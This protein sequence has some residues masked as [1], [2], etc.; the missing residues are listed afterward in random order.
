[1]HPAASSKQL[2]VAQV[3]APDYITSMFFQA[4][5]VAKA[6]KKASFLFPSTVAVS[7]IYLVLSCLICSQVAIKM[8]WQ[9]K[10]HM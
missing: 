8:N 4:L 10:S 5:K 9:M 7:H 6:L 1:M 2:L 3:L